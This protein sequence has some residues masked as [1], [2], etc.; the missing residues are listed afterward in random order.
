M[1]QD[2]YDGGDDNDGDDDDDDDDPPTP[3]DPDS[4][5]YPPDSG[6]RIR[7]PT[8]IQVGGGGACVHLA[9]TPK[10]CVCLMH[11]PPPPPDPDP[12]HIA[13]QE[14]VPGSAINSIIGPDP[15]P[16][17][18]RKPVSP[19]YQILIP[20]SAYLIPPPPYPPQTYPAPCRVQSPDPDH[21]NPHLIYFRQ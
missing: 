16:P 17:H 11:T 20:N 18:Y 14:P 10:L 21:S 15:D 1:H 12:A 4:P 9:Y 8:R 19:G 2:C 3:P 5:H 6:S 7:I 13:P